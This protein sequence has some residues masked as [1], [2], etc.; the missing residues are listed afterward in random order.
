[1]LCIAILS[2]IV[3][4]VRT[5]IQIVRD[6]VRTVCDW[7]S[8]VITTIKEVVER[9]CSWLPWPLNK[10]CNWV[11]KLIEVV[12]TVWDWVCREVIERIIDWIEIIVEYVIYILKWVCWVIDWIVRGPALL[13]CLL[14]IEPRRFMGVCVKILADDA[15]NPGIPLATVQ[16]MMRDAAAI[17]RRCNISMV[18]CSIEIIRKPEYLDSTTCDFSGMFKR[19][20]TWF[21]ANEC[22]CCS[23]VTVY[24]VRNIVDASG[25]AYPGTNWVTVAADGSGCTVVQEIG[26]LADLW[27]HSDTP[28]NVMANPCGDSIT[29]FQCCMIRT[30]RF[31]KAI[32]PCGLSLR[33][34]AHLEEAFEES[35]GEPF[36]R[37]ERGGFV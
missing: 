25:C 27:A 35:I 22:S 32:P 1:M 8:S 17:L 33:K 11:T 6:I 2:P 36:E 5:F 21:S 23:N 29:D 14:G 10:L 20:F 31:V 16:A 4:L 26:H 3:V 18:V 13:L 19:F 15:G 7:V 37:E 24:F 34:H 9:V 12:E 30:S 28:G